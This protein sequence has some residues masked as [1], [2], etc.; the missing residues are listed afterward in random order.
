MGIETTIV[1]GVVNNNEPHVW[2]LLKLEDDYYYM[3][4][5]WGENRFGGMKDEEL[6]QAKELFPISYEYFL[7]NVI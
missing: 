5:T 1:Y 4:L 6:L 7:I 2:N 3:D